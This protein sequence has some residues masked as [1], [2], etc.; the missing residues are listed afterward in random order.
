MN[1]PSREEFTA[2]T[3][4]LYET[5]DAGFKGVH[6]RLDVLNGRT[7][8]GEIDRENLR[9]RVV[10]LEKEIFS[11]PRRRATDTPP[12]PFFTKREGALVGLGIAV[13][14]ALLKFMLVAGEFAIEL[15]KAALKVK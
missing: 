10:S 7:L 14:A 6:T 12:P 4:R 13:V 11:E 15:G 8:K 1:G 9:T 2:F 3:D 5:T